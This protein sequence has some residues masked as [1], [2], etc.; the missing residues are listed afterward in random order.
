MI[1]PIFLFTNHYSTDSLQSLIYLETHNEI[2]RV[3]SKVILNNVLIDRY[4][5]LGR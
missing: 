4:I 2:L 5:Q 3:P 1:Y